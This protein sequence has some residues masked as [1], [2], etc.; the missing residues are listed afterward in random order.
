[1]AIASPGIGSGLDVNSIVGQLMAIERRP[2]AALDGKEAKQQAQLTA[3]GSLKG[4]LSSFQSSVTKLTDT[5]I[6]SAVTANFS[7]K[8]IAS[9]SADSSAI[10]GNYSVEVQSLAQSQKLKSSNFASTSSTVGS[11]TLTIQFGT[12]DGGTFTSNPEKVSQ[13]I[14]IQP[15]QSSL[16]GVRDTIN[17]AD[18]GVSASIINDGSGDRL[19]LTSIDTGVS[20]ALRITVADDDANNTDN[21]GLSQLAFDASTGG[22][23]NLTETVAAENANLIIDGINISKASNTITDAI[24]GVT[25][26]LLKA[27]IGN[28][29]TLTIEPDHSSTQTALES[30]VKGYNALNTTITDLSKFDAASN[31]ASVLTGDATVRAVQSRLRSVFNSTLNTTGGGLSTLSEIGISFQKDGTLELDS[32][33]LQEV[34]DDPTKDISSLF[35]QTGRTS[36]SLVSFVGATENT[37]E[38][39]YAVDITQLSTQGTATGSTPSTLT[40]LSGINDQLE[41]SIDGSDVSITL[42]ASVYTAATLAAEIQSKTNAALDISSADINVSVTESGG[43]LTITSDSYGSA[44]SVSITGGNAESGLFGT[45]TESNGLNVGGTIGGSPATGSNINTLTSIA[46]DSNGLALT[47]E[48]NTTGARGIVEYSQGFAYQIDQLITNMLDND[49]LIES[50]IDGINSS[51]KDIGDQRESLSRR[52]E[53]I[54]KRYRAQYSALDTLVASM[55]TTSNFLQQQ[56]ANL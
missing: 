5:A 22:T 26:N 18:V 46:G 16:V 41:L 39:I 51:V 9:A 42:A 56:L 29:S 2:L 33:K 27:D 10:A 1:M 50:R 40:I 23:S 17:D 49:S 31:R 13:S 32:S 6:F 24:E 35:A 53:D 8:D 20:N 47:I 21:A 55:T 37:Q 14:T 54:E 4:A 44:S 11:G 28:T 34:L 15:G 52:L 48:G 12:Y 43:I 36:D 19:V 25:L 3:Y 7:D 45:A 30:F 38:G